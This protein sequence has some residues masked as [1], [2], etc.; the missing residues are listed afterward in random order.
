MS[1]S[2]IFF[3]RILTSVFNSLLLTYV[4]G[5]LLSLRTILNFPFRYYSI[6]YVPATLIAVTAIIIVLTRKYIT[7]SVPS[8]NRFCKVIKGLSFQTLS[9]AVLCSNSAC[10]LVIINPYYH[11]EKNWYLLNVGCALAGVVFYYENI[12]FEQNFHFPIIQTTKY[13]MFMSKLSEIIF[14]SIKKS[15]FYTFFIFILLNVFEPNACNAVYFFINLWFSISLILYLFYSFEH[16]VYLIMTERVMFPIFTLNQDSD[17]LLNALNADNKTIQ[18]LALYDLYQATINDSERRKEIFSLSFAGNISQSWKIIFNYCV[19]NIKSTMDD[20]TNLVKHISPKVISRRK[21]PNAR[22]IKLN[23]NNDNIQNEDKIEK[24]NM[25]IK[26]L[27]TFSVYNYF[28]GPLDKVKSLEEFEKT[29]WCCYILSNLTVVSLKED[30]YGVVREHLEQIISI[31]LDLNNKLEHQKMHFN[32]QEIRNMEYLK[33]HVRTCAIML[34]LKFS[35]YTND[36]GL[37]ESHLHSLKK[38]IAL[39]NNL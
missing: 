6:L 39:L 22:L 37:D 20:M 18:S 26:F 29:V 7:T 36:I 28:F 5:F 13:S 12:Y 25:F 8:T 14:K 23:D 19:N 17:S 9:L 31:I 11:D 1:N 10:F 33:I 2:K 35:R 4:T 3:A 38:I 32:S 27:E 16:I 34:A 15:F 21:V 24:Q 30:E